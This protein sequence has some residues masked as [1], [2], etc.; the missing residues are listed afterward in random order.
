MRQRCRHGATGTRDQHDVDVDGDHAVVLR[1]GGRP[2]HQLISTIWPLTFTLAAPW[3]SMS[4]ALGVKVLSAVRV[5]SPPTNST[6]T[7]SPTRGGLA[8]P[9]SPTASAT[10]GSTRPVSRSSTPQA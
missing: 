10:R 7:R 1:R 2:G 5:L 3:I 9:V 8:A 4:V 6:T